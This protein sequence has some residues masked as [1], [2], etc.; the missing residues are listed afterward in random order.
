MPTISRKTLLSRYKQLPKVH[1]TVLQLCSIIYCSAPQST[2]HACLSKVKELLPY[3]KIWDSQQTATYLNTLKSKELLDTDNKPQELI[4]EYLAREAVYQDHFIPMSKAV[5]KL[6][7]EAPRTWWNTDGRGNIRDLR[8]AV[9]SKN[10]AMYKKKMRSLTTLDPDNNKRNF[11]LH[12]ILFSD[13]DPRWYLEQ[14]QWFIEES[15]EMVL[16]HC[17]FFGIA[18]SELI[19]YCEKLIADPRETGPEEIRQISISVMLMALAGDP[20]RAMDLLVKKG[21]LTGIE[22]LLPLCLALQGQTSQALTMFEKELGD[23]RKRLKRRTTTFMGIQGVVFLLV[24]LVE[25]TQESLQKGALLAKQNTAKPNA[26]SLSGSIAPAFQAMFASKM[27]MEQGAKNY[28]GIMRLQRA[29]SPLTEFFLLLAS[30]IV[31]TRLDTS[32]LTTLKNHQ[33]HFRANG[34]LWLALESGVLLQRAGQGTPSLNAFIKKTESDGPMASLLQ[35]I[36]I[37]EK[38]ERSLNALIR[39]GT[40]ETSCTDPSNLSDSRLIWCVSGSGNQ[41]NLS[42]R[43]Q[44]RVRSGGWSKGREISLKRLMDLDFPDLCSEDEAICH[45]I[46]RSYYPNY[47]NSGAYAFNWTATLPVLIGGPRIVQAENTS[48]PVEFIAAEPEVEVRNNTGM[49]SIKLSVLPEG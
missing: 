15:C 35:K 10:Q 26:A 42:A 34:A 14:P 6:I 20:K 24:Y 33:Q 5:Q 22:G 2:I 45:T 41:L 32:E 28:L 43:E 23:M 36:R 48:I 21:S 11:L 37:E 7:P 13:F 19:D 30:Y 40:S 27:G 1:K 25:G 16:T 31:M 3:K 12:P 8:I 17:L 18:S 29:S 9:Y 39:A 38:W 44:K 46:E 4:A 47:R 49:L